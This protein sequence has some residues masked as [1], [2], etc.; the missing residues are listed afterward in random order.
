MPV[1]YSFACSC[2]TSIQII[3]SPSSSSLTCLSFSRYWKLLISSL[4]KIG[5]DKTSVG[6]STFLY[7]LLILWI[8][9]ISTALIEIETSS[10]SILFSSKAVFTIVEISSVISLSHSFFIKSTKLSSRSIFILFIFNS[11]F[12]I[13]HLPHL[14]YK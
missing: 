14:M 1:S 4:E 12:C 8:V 6:L 3:I 2:K 11:S 10:V 13:F 9:S 5:K 7:S